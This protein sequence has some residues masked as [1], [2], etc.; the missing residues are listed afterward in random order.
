MGTRLNGPPIFLRENREMISSGVTF[1]TIQ[2]L[3]DGQMIILMAD[4]QT[5]GGYPKIGSIIA[6][7][8]PKLAQL[9]LGGKLSLTPVAVETAES[10]ALKF[11]RD[12]RLLRIGVSFSHS[13]YLR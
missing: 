11:E 4:H 2:L 1:G 5:T 8:L 3:P 6:S 10:A 13:A 9:G 12:L 7:D